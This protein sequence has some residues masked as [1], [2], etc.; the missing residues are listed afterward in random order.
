MNL[1]RRRSLAEKLA[2]I[3]EDVEHCTMEALLE[4]ARACNRLPK[5]ENEI[6]D[7]DWTTPYLDTGYDE[8]LYSWS[9]YIVKYRMLDSAGKKDQWFALTSEEKEYLR[10]WGIEKPT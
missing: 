7:G 1:K 5:W 6:L 3:S 10:T 2:H 8:A 9:K 4:E